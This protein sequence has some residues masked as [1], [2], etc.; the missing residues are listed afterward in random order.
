MYYLL[1]NISL[2]SGKI[3]KQADLACCQ[4]EF[5]SY[6][7]IWS[8]KT[9]RTYFPKQRAGVNPEHYQLWP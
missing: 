9:T 1:K 4:S 6:H 2:R 5:N 8:P 7:Y 3:L